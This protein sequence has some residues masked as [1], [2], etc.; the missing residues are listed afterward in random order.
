MLK[1]CATAQATLPSGP[2]PARETLKDARR[3]AMS[4]W[5]ARCT[6]EPDSEIS[7]PRPLRR[8]SQACDSTP[9]WPWPRRE[10]I[11]SPRRAR[12]RRSGV[13][14]KPGASRGA[15]T[16]VSRRQW[17]VALARSPSRWITDPSLTARVPSSF[18]RRAAVFRDGTAGSSSRLAHAQPKP[19]RIRRELPRRVHRVPQRRPRRRGGRV[20][21][22]PTNEAYLVG[23]TATLLVPQARM[24]PRRTDRPTLSPLRQHL[25][26]LEHRTA[27]RGGRT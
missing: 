12:R 21:P 6:G 3:A 17:R 24:T 25:Y 5:S 15:P 8:R 9:A 7:V 26:D 1:A 18:A 4:R 13:A 11:G 22:V 14:G 10:D 20:Q 27:S 2:R 23:G 19:D 16:D